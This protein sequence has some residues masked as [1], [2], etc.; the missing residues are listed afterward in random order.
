MQNLLQLYQDRALRFRTQAQQLQQRYDRLSFVRLGV[1]TLA[2]LATIFFWSLA[3]WGG[4]LFI[5][6]FILGFYRFVLWHQAIQESARHHE[7]LAIINKHEADTLQHNYAAFPTGK[8][9]LQTDHPYALDLDLFGEYS[10][11]Q[12][13]CRASTAIGQAKLAN[14]LLHPL[15]DEQQLKTRQIAVGELRE[16]LDWRQH[17]Q[18]YGREA[19]DD[20]QHLLLLHQWLED[21]DFVSNNRFLKLALYLAPVWFA[22]GVFLWWTVFSW[23]FMLLFLIPPALILRRTLDQVNFIHRRTTHAGDTL[24]LYGKLIEHIQGH[25]F[26]SPLLQQLHSQLGKQEQTASSYINRLAY[27]ITQLNVRFNVFAIFLNLIGLWDLQW[28]Y[29]LE[30]WKAGLRHELPLWF[31]VLSDIEALSSLGNLWY[32]NPEWIMPELDQATKFSALDIAHPLIQRNVRIGNDLSMPTRGHIKLITGSN[33]AGKSTFL[34][35]IGLNLVLAQAGSPV[36]AKEMSFPTMQVYTSMRTQDALHE[37][38]SSFYAELKRLKVIIEAVDAANQEDHDQLPVFFLLDEILKGTNSVDRHTGSASL[39]RQLI[40][41]KGGGLIATH[42]LEL[43]RLEAEAEGAI[44]NLRI[45]VAI[46]EGILD[47]D[48]KLKKGVSE[49]FNATLLMKQMGIRI[50]EGE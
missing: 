16:Q 46:K 19:N 17:F 13:T 40:R 15:A 29:R 47:F 23:H 33:M 35:T 27:I 44:E 7:Q 3:W 39:I 37:S 48:Y 34:R 31:E 50:E 24:S 12:Y 41:Q 14:Y 5:V 21:P 30:K 49:S 10:F 20:P 25:T 36:C 26:D 28:I 6:L 32:N 11:F 38:T 8:T 9:F 18:A 43:G 1:F 45:E 2:I 22:I 42:D 4:I